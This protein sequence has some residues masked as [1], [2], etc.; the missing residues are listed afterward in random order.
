MNGLTSQQVTEPGIYTWVDRKGDAHVG[1]IMVDRRGRLS[2]SFVGLDGS[3]RVALIGAD[4]SDGLFCGP[5]VLP[6]DLTTELR[7]FM[8][9]GIKG[10]TNPRCALSWLELRDIA[11]K[12]AGAY[13]DTHSSREDAY[14][15]ER[16]F[17]KPSRPHM[18]DCAWSA[19]DDGDMLRLVMQLGINLR[20]E[21]VGTAE[22]VIADDIR[23][24]SRGNRDIATREAILR[25]VAARTSLSGVRGAE[26][27]EKP[28]DDVVPPPAAAP[29]PAKKVSPMASTK[30][31]DKHISLPGGCGITKM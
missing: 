10:F 3:M 27:A 11:A 17:G 13:R 16:D 31:F 6:T 8:I 15:I 12:A 7:A 4:G 1:V 2:S 22:T 14:R 19:D 5:L 18:V 26:P 20:F 28:V 24:P 21:G 30:G 23:L 9:M 25:A 29:A